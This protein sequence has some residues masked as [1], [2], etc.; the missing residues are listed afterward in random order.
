MKQTNVLIL[1]SIEVNSFAPLI[2]LVFTVD[3]VEEMIF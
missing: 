2:P 3:S 1:V